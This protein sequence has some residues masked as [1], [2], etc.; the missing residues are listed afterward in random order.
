MSGPS[1]LALGFFAGAADDEGRGGEVEQSD[2]SRES[3]TT[4]GGEL[5]GVISAGV[6]DSSASFRSGEYPGELDAEENS[7]VAERALEFASEFAAAMIKKEKKK[8]AEVKS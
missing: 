6:E 3:S 5:S 1:R 8:K 7:D 4:S 2:C